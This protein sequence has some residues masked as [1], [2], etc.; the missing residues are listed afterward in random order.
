MIGKDG[1]SI[2]ARGKRECP[3]EAF[4]CLFG[5]RQLTLISL[6]T[7]QSLRD[8]CHSLTNGLEIHSQAVQYLDDSFIAL[9]DQSEEEMFRVY[10]TRMHAYRFALC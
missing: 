8:F 6:Q 1:R 10:L 7:A 3:P 5:Q 2:H 4:L 9:H